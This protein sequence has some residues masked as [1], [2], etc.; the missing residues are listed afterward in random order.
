ME[1]LAGLLAE[2]VSA[3]LILGMA[4]LAA[5][6]ALLKGFKPRTVVIMGA[7]I[8]AINA[9]GSFLAAQMG[10]HPD[11]LAAI[12]R[13]FDQM[14][15]MNAKNMADQKI[16]PTEI[17][18]F[19]KI[20][21]K[22]VEQ[23]F[24]AWILIGAMG[25]GFVAYYLV[26]SVVSRSNPRVFPP[27]PFWQW[28]VPEPLVFGLIMALLIKV[29]VPENHWSDIV[30]NNLLVFFSVIYTFAGVTI[31]SYYFQRWRLPG[32]ARVIGY[33]AIIL[34]TSNSICVLG[35]LDIWMDFRK[36]KKPPMEPAK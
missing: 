9:G 35:V 23:A 29:L 7:A 20:W 28:M 17:E 10:S 8:V 26:S 22:Y 4:S 27:L 16:S 24:P 19:R 34:L 3:F 6:W 14:W 36:L 18:F 11:S 1:I 30:A 32:L 33:L 13:V 15:Q 21:E 31:V 5:Y 2:L 12:H 25:A